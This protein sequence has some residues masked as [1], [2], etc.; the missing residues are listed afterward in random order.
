M[1][2]W[3]LAVGATMGQVLCIPMLIAG[4]WLICA[5]IRPRGKPPGAP[6]GA[7]TER[8]GRV[9]GARANAAYY[10]AHDPFAD[11]TTSPEITQVFGELLGLWAATPG[12]CWGGRPPCS[13]SR[14]G[15]A[16]AP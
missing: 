5:L 3:F 2:S 11:F 15:P 8:L 1:R 4:A 13:W 14:R 9:H 7:M 6:A 12:G 10:A 16:A